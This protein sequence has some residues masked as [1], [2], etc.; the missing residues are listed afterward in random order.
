MVFLAEN[1]VSTW[2]CWFCN[3]LFGQRSFVSLRTQ[4]LS[5][6]AR[7]EW[8]SHCSL[9]AFC[10]DFEFGVNGENSVLTGL[11][12]GLRVKTRNNT[13]D[14]YGPDNSFF[15]AQQQDWD[16]TQ[17]GSHN[18]HVRMST[19]VSTSPSLTCTFCNAYR[20]APAGE[21]VPNGFRTSGKIWAFGF[22]ERVLLFPT[23][24][25]VTLIFDLCL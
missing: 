19:W 23:T 7:L 1:L 15:R 25:F 20:S 10:G 4:P 12:L 18:A 16:D 5:V 3:I 14:T 13:Y 24:S 6:H 11:R 2:G 22:T 9:R 17:R 8:K 21:R